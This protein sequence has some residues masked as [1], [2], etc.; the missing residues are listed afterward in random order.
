VV[1]VVRIPRGPFVDA[2]DRRDEIVEAILK[3]HRVPITWHEPTELIALLP[4]ENASLVQEFSHMTGRP[5]AVGAAH[6]RTGELTEA[7][8]LARR[9]SH[10]APVESTPT[11]LHT[12]SD[13][14]V[15]L[16][17]QHIP[18]VDSW[19][20]ELVQQLSAGPNLVRTLDAF[21][22][23]EMNRLHT[24]GALH[25]H[26]RT[27]DYRLQRVRELVGI[28]PTS[29]RGVRTLSTAITLALARK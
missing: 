18:Q 25:I 7:L 5:C 13:L 27:L 4:D 29:T 17:V 20:R 8:A 21:Y 22:R 3:D 1:A 19:L 28:D 24:A 26:P 23:N 6:G 16:G 14:F 10:V 2:E 9:L 11:R 15:E 12:V